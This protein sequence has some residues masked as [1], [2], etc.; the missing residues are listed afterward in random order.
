[1]GAGGPRLSVVVPTYD[2]VDLLKRCIDDLR[3]QTVPASDYEIVVVDDA[4]KTPV[5][6]PLEPEYRSTAPE[7]V[8]LRVEENSPAR[9]RN[10]GIKHARAPIVLFIGDDIF[11]RPNMV[12]E[13]LRAHER[14]SELVAVLGKLEDDPDL[15]KSAFERWFD[16]FGYS[17]LRGDQELDCRFFWTN[18]ISVKTEL[19]RRHGGFDEDFSDANHEDVELGYRLERAGMRIRYRDIVL[20]Y[21][22]H[23]YT[24]ASACRLLY[25]RG[26]TYRILRAKVPDEV[27]R[28][29]LGIF[30]W[31]NSPRSIIRGLVRQV[32]VNDLTAG[33]WSKWL[34]RDKD[35]ALRRFFYWKLLTY[36]TNKGY[37][38]ADPRR[39][40]ASSAPLATSR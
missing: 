16:P 4:S 5:A 6:P 39:M 22:R 30:S 8:W 10:L 24:L 20:G 38:D 28:E 32:L 13:H 36:Y 23:P 35:S 31:R 19:L 25:R 14:T 18:N 26:A 11:A 2:R 1:M 7:I 37:R 29:H 15:P 33:M 34:A 12:E 27:F 40:R 9:A 3:R 17:L 21:H